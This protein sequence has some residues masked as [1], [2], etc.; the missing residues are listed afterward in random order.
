MI[1]EGDFGDN[2]FTKVHNDQYQLINNPNKVYYNEIQ[3]IWNLWFASYL[4][5]GNY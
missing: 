2:C 3:Y 4:Y 1:T 5:V